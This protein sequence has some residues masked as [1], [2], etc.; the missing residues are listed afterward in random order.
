LDNIPIPDRAKQA[1]KINSKKRF[2]IGTNVSGGKRSDY[3]LLVY[4]L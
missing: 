2:S 4:V 1:R 3:W